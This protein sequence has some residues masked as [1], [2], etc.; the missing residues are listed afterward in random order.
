MGRRAVWRRLIIAQWNQDWHRAINKQIVKMLSSVTGV[1]F[2]ALGIIH[3]AVLP[4]YDKSSNS[5]LHQGPYPVS[6]KTRKFHEKVFVADLHADS[7]LWSRNLTNR[8]RY[9]HVDLPRLLEGGVDLQVFSAVSKVPRSLNY[10]ANRSDSD[11]LSLLFMVSLRPPSTWF[12]SKHRA[13]AQASE[14]K[15]ATDISPFKFVLNK[16]DLTRESN[17]VLLALEGM[18]V[19]EGAE[20][21]L[22]EFFQAGF[23][24]MGLVHFFD[25]EVAGSAHGVEKYGLTNLGRSIIP[26]LESRGIT[27]DLAH[28]SP[29]SIAETLKLAKKP[30]V[31]SHGGV[32]GTCP[33]PRNLS[34]SQLKGIAENGGVIGI[35]FW[36]GAVCDA[37]MDGIIRAILYAVKIAGIDHVGLG[38]DFDG[39]VSTPFDVTGLPMLTESL[40]ASGLTEEDVRKVLGLNVRRVLAENLP[41]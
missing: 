17:R 3:Y 34:D 18:H 37:S 19:L 31:V 5:I 1:I 9:G 13:L 11:I 29:R 12:S 38:S 28:A 15:Q 23:R 41:E 26:Q 16:K 33:G 20:N 30:V 8:N 39:H 24:M 25:N 7:L 36:K 27:V 22:D 21:V 35:G 14:L 32:Q 6:D 2:L 40:L 4:Y 10:Y